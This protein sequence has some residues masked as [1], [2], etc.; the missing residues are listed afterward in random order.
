MRTSVL[1]FSSD[2]ILKTVRVLLASG[3]KLSVPVWQAG[4]LEKTRSKNPSML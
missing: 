3:F 4:G 1:Y 2:L